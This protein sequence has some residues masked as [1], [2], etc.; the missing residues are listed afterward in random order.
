VRFVITGA[1]DVALQVK[2]GRA[3]AR[4]VARKKVTR[5]GLQSLTWNGKIGRR[6]APR[7]LYT[8]TVQATK[9]GTTTSSRLRVRLR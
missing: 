4:T 6:N 3:A 2:R 8:L 9:N 1:A 5:A 7:G